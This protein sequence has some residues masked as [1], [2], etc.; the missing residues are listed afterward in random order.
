M[1]NLL[2]IVKSKADVTQLKKGLTPLILEFQVDAQTAPYLVSSSKGVLWINE[3]FAGDPPFIK[4]AIRKGVTPGSIFVEA[5]KAIFEKATEMRWGSAQ[6]FTEE[7]LIAAIDHVSSYSVGSLDVLVSPK[8]I[9]D[10]GTLPFWIRDRELGENLRAADWVPENCIIV[11]PSDRSFLGM[12]VH[13]SPLSTAM[14]IHNAARG[15]A[16]CW[17]PVRPSS[18]END[19]SGRDRSSSRLPGG[20]Y[21]PHTTRKDGDLPKIPKGAGSAVKPRSKRK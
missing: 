3:P 15:F 16:M 4:A 10:G 18:Q 5:A 2:Q 11:I 7:G 19:T 20:G 12:L 6:P 17:T 21:Q 14:A 1:S 9:L 13:L 8:P